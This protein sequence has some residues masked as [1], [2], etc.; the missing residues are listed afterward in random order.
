PDVGVESTLKEMGVPLVI[1][2]GQVWLRVS[3]YSSIFRILFNATYLDAKHSSMA[4]DLLTRSKF[5]KGLRAG[6]P[7][8]IKIAHKFGER[9]FGDDFQLHDCGIVYVPK[10]PYL[11]CVMTRGKAFDD[12]SEAI[13]NIS[14]VVYRNV[15]AQ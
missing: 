14:D 2:D 1:S 15:S 7:T 5:M 11:L 9:G 8:D 6:L 4:L 12:L 13:R 10:T 3:S